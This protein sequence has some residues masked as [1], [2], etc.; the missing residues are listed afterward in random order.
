MGVGIA[1]YLPVSTI[2][3]GVIGAVGGWIYDRAGGAHA[4]GEAAKRLGVLMVSGL[5]VGESLFN[6]ALAAMV[7]ATNSGMLKVANP[8][9]PIAVVSENFAPAAALGLAAFVS[10]LGLYLWTWRAAGV[11]AKAKRMMASITRP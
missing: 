9:A 6:V 5:I 3:P 2:V 1:V 10:I 7:A 11:Q 8:I 4:Y